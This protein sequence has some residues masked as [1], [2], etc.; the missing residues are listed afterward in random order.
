[1]FSNFPFESRH[2]GLFPELMVCTQVNRSVSG[3]CERLSLWVQ[4]SPF[5]MGPH[6]RQGERKGSLKGKKNDELQEFGLARNS[7]SL[8]CFKNSYWTLPCFNYTLFLLLHVWIYKAHGCGTVQVWFNSSSHNFSHISNQ[9][10][11]EW[12]P[13]GFPH[14]GLLGWWWYPAWAAPCS[15]YRV[16][17]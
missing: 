14:L 3:L 16:Q 6:K 11:E 7:A 12:C 15:P 2:K 9:R 4:G 1:M 8:L 17:D 10:Y 5:W 13:C